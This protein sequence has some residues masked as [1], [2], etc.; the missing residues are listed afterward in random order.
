MMKEL[1]LVNG[2][3]HY[4][5]GCSC[6]GSPRFY[7]HSDHFDYNV[8]VRNNRFSIKKGNEVLITDKPEQLKQAL[9]RYEL[10]Q[11]DTTENKNLEA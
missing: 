6:N 11:K 5:T 7:K 2:W 10:I 8:I 4:K 1:L 3:E 9:E